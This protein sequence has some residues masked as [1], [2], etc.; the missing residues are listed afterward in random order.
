MAKTHIE[1]DITK[2]REFGKRLKAFRFKTGYSQA[3]MAK[4][5]QVNQQQISKYELDLDLPGW[6][7]RDLFKQLQEI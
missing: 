5:L 1:Y 3:F 2:A 4:V 6:G 7:V